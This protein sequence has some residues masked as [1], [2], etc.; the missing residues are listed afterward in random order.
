MTRSI[1]AALHELGY[2]LA[3][4]GPS[5]ESPS[6]SDARAIT[7][8]R[9]KDD[10]LIVTA[11]LTPAAISLSRR[12]LQGAVS[13]VGASFAAFLVHLADLGAGGCFWA[14]TPWSAAAALQG[15]R[16]I[17]S[18]LERVKQQDLRVLL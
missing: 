7:T 5:G 13:P 15:P 10:Q 14:L 9:L 17:A 12:A 1:E 3:S 8:V 18:A 6:A 2:R 16:A 11:G 4:R